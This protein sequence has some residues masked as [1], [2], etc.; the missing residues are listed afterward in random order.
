MERCLPR[1]MQGDR[2]SYRTRS[3]KKFPIPTQNVNALLFSTR[4][5]DEITGTRE[6][7]TVLDPDFG[8]RT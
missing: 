3:E 4:L 7:V 2:L 5:S 8:H 1:E 6:V